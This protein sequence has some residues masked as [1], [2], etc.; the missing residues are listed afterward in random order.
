M[1]GGGRIDGSGPAPTQIRRTTT[2]LVVVRGTTLLL[3]LSVAGWLVAAVV[4]ADGPTMVDRRVWTWMVSHRSALLTTFFKT[5]TYLGGAIGM[6]VLATGAAL[7][8]LLLPSRRGDGLLVAVVA[9]GAGLLVAVSKPLIGRTRPPP[10]FRLVT[11]NNDSFPSAHALSSAAVIGVVTVVLVRGPIALA[12]RVAATSV[13][14][15]AVLLIGVSRLYLGVHW[16]TDVLGGWA[17]GA[18]WLT[19]C[20]TVRDLWGRWPAARCVRADSP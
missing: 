5:V 10:A 16:A 7:V 2:K 3:L 11:E 9:V 13:A 8:L 4:V 20:T 12:V 15:G 1:E 17:V 6:T 19:L 18:A 14:V